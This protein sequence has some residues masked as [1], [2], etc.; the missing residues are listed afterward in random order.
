M[1]GQDH[2]AG[3]LAGRHQ[4]AI[5]KEKIE[6]GLQVSS[7]NTKDTKDTKET[8]VTKEKCLHRLTCVDRATPKDSQLK[9]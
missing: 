3:A 5:D 7:L 4:T 8:K 1:P 6:A 2:G 9:T